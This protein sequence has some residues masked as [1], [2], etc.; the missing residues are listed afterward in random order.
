[1]SVPFPAGTRDFSLSEATILALGPTQPSFQWVLG[2]KQLRHEADHPSPSSAE[3]KNRW[4]CTSTPMYIFVVWSRTN[5][6]YSL[7]LTSTLS[8]APHCI[9][10]SSLLF[11]TS[12]GR[13]YKGESII[14]RS[15]FLTYITTSVEIFQVHNFS[16]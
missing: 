7:V 11:V 2:I 8:E 3:I 5:S 9:V 1:M 14:F 12:V 16:A 13:K 6:P 15:V 4:S 10:S